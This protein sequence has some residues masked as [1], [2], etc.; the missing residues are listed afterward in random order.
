[1]FAIVACTLLC[2]AGQHHVAQHGQSDRPARGPVHIGWHDE[3]GSAQAWDALNVENKAH[4]KLESP[5]NLV[6]SLGQ[7]PSGWPYT[8]QWSGLK[9]NVHADIGRHPVLMAYVERIQGYAHLDID[10]LDA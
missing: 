6:L 1:M 2:L 10:V 8:F 9:R 3:F 5:G 7:V 4:V